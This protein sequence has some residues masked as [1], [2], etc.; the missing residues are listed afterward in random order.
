MLK[1]CYNKAN[2]TAQE[3]FPMIRHICM[4]KL[5]EE[6]KEANIARFVENAKTITC[7]PTVKNYEVRVNSEKANPANYEVALIFDF[8]SWEDLETYRVHP[9][10]VAFGAFVRTIHE[11]RACIDY[12]F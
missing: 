4:F 5:Q 12:E 8:E 6:N 7:I 10:H 3:V 1:A 11:S 2:T 9:D